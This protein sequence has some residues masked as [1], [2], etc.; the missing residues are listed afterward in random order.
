MRI[1]PLIPDVS[2][3]AVQRPASGAGF[4][5]ALDALGAVFQGAERAENA[6]ADGAGDLQTAVYQRARADVAL[7]VASAAAQRA[8][9]A[10]QTLLNMQ[11]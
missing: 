3:A 8:A 7:S 1:E 10:L 2:P 5:Q 6:F 11:I 9:A 4:A